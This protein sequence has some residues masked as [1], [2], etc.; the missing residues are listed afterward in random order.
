MDSWL[1]SQRK[2]LQCNVVN[3]NLYLWTFECSSYVPRHGELCEGEVSDLLL[4]GYFGV[5]SEA[6]PEPEGLISRSAG[7]PLSI[8]AECKVEDSVLVPTEVSQA[9]EGG[10]GVTPD[11]EVVL[12]PTVGGEELMVVGG[13]Q[14]ATHLQKEQ[15]VSA[16][17]DYRVSTRGH[18]HSRP[19]VCT[20][21]SHL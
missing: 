8:W 12:W 3:V 1:V 19:L 7:N 6:F 11:G 2:G 20:W 10:G 15:R 13:P 21:D 18:L 16:C 17:N 14:E 5:N 4:F 9:G